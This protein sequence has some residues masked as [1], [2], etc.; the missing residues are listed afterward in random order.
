[1]ALSTEELLKPRYLAVGTGDNHYPD[2]PFNVRDAIELDKIDKGKP[3]TNWQYQY[4]RHDGV[5]TMYQSEF[6]EYP[7]LFKKLEW[8]EERT[9]KEID[10]VFYVKSKSGNSFRK[11]YKIDTRTKKIT[12][13]KIEEDGLTTVTILD[14]WLPATQSEYEQFKKTQP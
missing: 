2:S 8:W 7:H 12:L 5:Y 13:F 6:D 9:Q 4:V 14:N 10:D 1:M 3:S 11:T